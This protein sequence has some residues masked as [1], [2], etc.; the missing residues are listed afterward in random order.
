MD[1]A[2]ENLLH[3]HRDI[4]SMLNVLERICLLINSGE[5]PDLVDITRIIYFLRIFADECHNGKEEK[6]L[7]PVL[8]KA[9]SGRHREQIG[10]LL[11]DHKTERELIATMQNSILG[12]SLEIGTF[13]KSSL[14]YV[15]LLRDHI[16]KENSI[17]DTSGCPELTKKKQLDLHDRML[18]FENK[19]IGFDYHLVYHLMLDKLGKQY[20][21]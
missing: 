19:V 4:Q 13:E 14:A 6:I 15:K 7:F 8:E 9:C 20:L 2:R 3:D 12:D 11:S 21:T 10:K 17:L 18:A 1:I 5:A 16:D